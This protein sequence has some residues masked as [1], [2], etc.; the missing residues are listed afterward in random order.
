M[1]EVPH[2]I[3]GNRT[4]SDHKTWEIGDTHVAG[5]LQGGLGIN[6]YVSKDS[7]LRGKFRF[8]HIS[9]PFKPDSGMTHKVVIV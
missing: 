1:K 8:N 3:R 9:D 4:N 6:H 5:T 7:E 2:P